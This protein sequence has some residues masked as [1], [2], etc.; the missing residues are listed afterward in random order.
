MAPKGK[1]LKA[2]PKQLVLAKMLGWPAWP[3]FVM[4]TKLIPPG[5]LKA[6]KKLTEYCVIFIPDGDF[7]WMNEKSIEVLSADKLEKRL[8]KVRPLLEVQGNGAGKKGKNSGSGR[9]LNVNDALLA[10]EGLKFDNFMRKLKE[11]NGDDDEEEDEEDDDYEEEDSGSQIK[12]ENKQGDN[13]DED[14]D[15]DEL[16]QSRSID[17]KVGTRKRSRLVKDE[18][19]ASPIL[20]GKPRGRPSRKRSRSPI[21]KDEENQSDDD[22]DIQLANRKIAKRVSPV[23]G[24][25]SPSTTRGGNKHVTKS[26]NGNLKNGSNDK[27]QLDERQHQLW[28]CRIKLQRSLIQRNQANTPTNPR[29]FPPPSADELSVARLILHK[30]ADMPVTTDL[31]KVTKIHKVLK[32]ILKDEDLEYPDSFKLHEKC[33][34]LLTKWLDVIE[35]IRLEK[36]QAAANAGNGN[37]SSPELTKPTGKENI[38]SLASES[39]SGSVPVTETAINALLAEGDDDGEA[40]PDDSEVSTIANGTE[41]DRKE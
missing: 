13:E 35:K 39:A 36:V 37:Q 19:G 8:A 10:A 12:K 18:D 5:V 34:E 11:R 25:S 27:E 14:D 4:P 21:I 6:K 33:Q 3:S 30:L 40:H 23:S 38:E 20:N 26:T 29:D 17:D 31:L 28:L 15:E 41:D 16:Q 22:L 32:C 1:G 7:Y 24:S 2:E 9:T